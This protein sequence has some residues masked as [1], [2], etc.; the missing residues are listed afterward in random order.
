MN[1]SGDCSSKSSSKLSLVHSKWNIFLRLAHFRFLLVGRKKK[2]LKQ[3]SY[4]HKFWKVYFFVFDC[5]IVQVTLPLILQ[6]SFWCNK[7]K[8][9]ETISQIVEN[10]DAVFVF[11]SVSL[12]HD[13]TLTFFNKGRSLSLRIVACNY[14]SS[15]KT[16]NGWF[17]SGEVSIIKTYEHI[18]FSIFHTI[19]IFRLNLA[20]K[21]SSLKFTSE[22]GDRRRRRH[23]AVTI[24]T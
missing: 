5:I 8:I 23:N 4:D 10:V 18:F 14:K 19:S 9:F 22:Q 20:P 16:Q 2:F 6:L 12:M 24:N 15:I 21:C 17:S 13:L 1:K 7:T 11:A 3:H